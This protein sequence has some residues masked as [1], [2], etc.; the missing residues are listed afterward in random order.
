[1]ALVESVPEL[2]CRVDDAMPDVPPI[3]KPPWHRAHW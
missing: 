1:M 2:F 3:P